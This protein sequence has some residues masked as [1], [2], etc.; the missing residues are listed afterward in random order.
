MIN[1]P[2]KLGKT[3]DCCG[4]QPLWGEPGNTSQN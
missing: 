3:Q 4:G 2:L 1:L